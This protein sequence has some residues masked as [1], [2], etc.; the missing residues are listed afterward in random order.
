MLPCT[1]CSSIIKSNH[2]REFDL[3]NIVERL[4]LVKQV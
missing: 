4:T 3:K 1:P 2:L